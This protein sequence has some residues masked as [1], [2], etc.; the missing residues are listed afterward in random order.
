MTR[1]APATWWGAGLNAVGALA[2]VWGSWR[3]PPGAAGWVLAVVVLGAVAWIAR[4][5]A[6][7]FAARSGGLSVA[8]ALAAAPVLVMAVAG[9]VAAV[10]TQG[11]AVVMAAIA[12]IV[13]LGDP[14]VP[15][16]VGA[17]VA[18]IA[19]LSVAGGAVAA[20]AGAAGPA[21]ERVGVLGIV[22]IYGGIALGVVGGLGRRAQRIAVIERDRAAAEALRA[23][24]T[25]SRVA[26]ARDLHDVLAHSL[27]GLVVQLD[28]AEA[29]LEAGETGPASAKVAEARG[30]AVA[31]LR[32]AREAVRALRVP[33][34]AEGPE[35]GA[36]EAVDASTAPSA[37]AERIEALV[38]A[39]RGLGGTAETTSSGAARPVPAAVATAIE[40]AVQEG[41]SNAR[42]HAPGA[43]V[44]IRLVWHPGRVECVIENP[45]VAKGG[46]DA[47]LAGTGGGYGLRGVRERF[48]ALGGTAD[49]GVAAGVFRIRAE[50]PS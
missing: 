41:L 46:A 38:A 45:V 17:I 18:G 21:G 27:G 19:A 2:V 42:K 34:G 10:P 14:R 36:D 33:S 22:A 32:E 31:G 7:A 43:P 37:L 16:A 44:S 30:L 40:R 39:H 3:T 35:E 29:L 6:G 12:V 13:A 4:S 11:V 15:P 50:A 47:A 48:A 28:A 20:Q 9:G 1:I 24:E 25:A 26:I 8:P 49:A 23:G 5:A